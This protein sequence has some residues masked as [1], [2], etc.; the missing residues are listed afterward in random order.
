[1]SLRKILCPIDFSDC[2]REAMRTAI[3]V[4]AES[5]ASLTL[6]HVWHFPAYAFAAEAPVPAELIQEVAADAERQLARWAGDARELGAERLSTALVQG[7]PWDR[8][9]DALQRDAGY[10]LAVV[11]THGR[12]GLKHVLLGSVAEKVVRHAP[13]PVLV[14]RRRV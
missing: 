11:G 13:C 1:M 8:V 2:S 10:D 7:V 14:V 3:K 6:M 5:G 9:V 12:T 4:A